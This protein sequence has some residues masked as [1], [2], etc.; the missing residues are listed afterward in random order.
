MPVPS[1]GLQ[2]LDLGLLGALVLE[3]LVLLAFQKGSG[4]K[5]LPEVLECCEGKGSMATK[6]PVWLRCCKTVFSPD[7]LDDEDV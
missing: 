1:L 3:T 2:S 6:G 7:S 4:M 5:I